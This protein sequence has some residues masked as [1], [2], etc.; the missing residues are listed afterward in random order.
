M[1][2][3]NEETV[4]K[5]CKFLEEGSIQ[6]D[7]AVLGGIS[8]PTFYEWLHKYP[9]FSERVKHAVSTYRNKLIK[10]VNVNSIKNGR[11]AL[12]VL[13]RRWPED[14]AQLQKVELIDP[15]IEIKKAMKI[16]EDEKVQEDS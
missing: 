3:Y 5:V 16:L 10:I 11:L 9:E 4:A 13:S 2:K 7:A 6:K 8:E 15:E 14:W 12:E 1:A